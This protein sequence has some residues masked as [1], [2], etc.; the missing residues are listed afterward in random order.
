MQ[1]Q[2]RTGVDLVCRLLRLLNYEIHLVQ[3]GIEQFS[4]RLP[5]LSIPVA[6]VALVATWV[7]YWIVYPGL[8][9]LVL[10]ALLVRPIELSIRRRMR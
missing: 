6:F 9:L 1:P 2:M 4:H 10:L 8:V 5:W 3:Y 7:I